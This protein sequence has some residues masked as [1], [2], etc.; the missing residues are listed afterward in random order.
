MKNEKNINCIKCKYYYN[1]WDAGLPKGCRKFGFKSKTMPSI[2]VQ[3]ETGTPCEGYELRPN[4]KAKKD[5]L[6]LNSDDL[7]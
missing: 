4:A 2:L 1:T 6:D 5:K 7:W 3:E